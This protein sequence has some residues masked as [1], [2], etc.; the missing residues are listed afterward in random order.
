M[1]QYEIIYDWCG[2]ESEEFN[3]TET[4]TGNWLELQDYI[5]R[6]RKNGCYKVN[7]LTDMVCALTTAVMW[8]STWGHTVTA[9]VV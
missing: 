9:G 6:M 1:E 2:E 5:K 3:L 7:F 4:F 8:F